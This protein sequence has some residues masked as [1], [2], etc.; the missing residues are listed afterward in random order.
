MEEGMVDRVVVGN[1]FQGARAEEVGH[2]GLEAAGEESVDIVV[3]VVGEDES[4]VLYIFFEVGAFLAVEL[5]KFVAAEVSEGI[6]EDV[7]VI[8]GD[9][10]FLQVYGDGG[11]FDEGIQKIIGHSL[12]GVPVAGAVAK[13]HESKGIGQVHRSCNFFKVDEFMA[14]FLIY[15]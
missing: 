7:G 11:V 8:E 9:D 6:I 13:P 5:D 10:F 3:A 4:P 15:V 2:L 1:F 12:I 14:N